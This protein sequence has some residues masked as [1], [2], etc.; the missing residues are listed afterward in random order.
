MKQV[1][2]VGIYEAKTHF[3][4]LLKE[5]E[6]GAHVKITRHGEVVADLQPPE[7][8]KPKRPTFGMYK[9]DNFYMSED[10][11]EPLEDFKETM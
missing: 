1:K 10:F 8:K 11:D 4:K 3:S 2:E 5:V 7:K 6:A 9:G